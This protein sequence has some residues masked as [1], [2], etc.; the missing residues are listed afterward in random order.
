MNKLNFKRGARQP[1]TRNTYK[2]VQRAGVIAAV[3][4]IR[5]LQGGLRRFNLSEQGGDE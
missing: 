4:P 1:Y 5:L 2:G 3:L